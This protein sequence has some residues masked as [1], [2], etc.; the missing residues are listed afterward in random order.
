KL[1]AGS[2]PLDRCPM[3]GGSITALGTGGVA[4]AWRRDTAVYFVSS[5]NKKEQLLGPGEHPWIAATG[6]GPYVAWVAKR[7]GPLLLQVPKQAKTIQL[8]PSAGDPCIAA[9]S[10]KGGLVVVAWEDRAT[11]DNKVICQVVSD[12]AKSR[13]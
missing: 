10:K 12:V 4:T 7:G 5:Q 2:W 1:G 13:T 3:D 9:Q 6:D 11:K 8:A